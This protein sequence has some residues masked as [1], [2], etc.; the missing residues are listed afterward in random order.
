MEKNY[1][2][3]QQLL[4]DAFA[5]GWQVFDS[6]FRP[7]YVVGVWRGGTPVGIA[8]H[9][10]LQMLGVRADHAAVR[11]SSYEGM[12]RREEAV[13]VEGLDYIVTRLQPGQAVLLVDDVHDTGLSLEQVIREL[14]AYQSDTDI[15]IATPWFKPGNNRSGRKPD[16]F[17]HQT[18]D[19][20]V[21]PHELDGLRLDEIEANKPELAALMPQLRQHLGQQR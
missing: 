1:I 16:Y 19:W 17:L 11:T 14:H 3:P 13:Q 12:D 5:L 8:V 20:L 21:F 18:G 9:E 15:R 7:D 6:G 2:S 4:A 10:L